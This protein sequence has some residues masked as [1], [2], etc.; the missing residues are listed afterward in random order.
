MSIEWKLRQIMAKND[1][2]T[3]SELLRLMEDKAGY[4]MSPASISALINDTPKLI[5]VETLDAL[6][7]AL[8]CTPNDL[9][10]HKS[11]FIGS[12]KTPR[13]ISNN[14]QEKEVVNKRPLPP[15]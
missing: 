4:S 10:V 2:W 11:S 7:T 9:V 13:V 3:G 15:V 8:D 5:R 1:V 12:M 14:K 6:C